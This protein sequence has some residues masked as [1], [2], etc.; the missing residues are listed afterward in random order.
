MTAAAATAP[1]R[2]V[3][4]V[5]DDALVGMGLSAYLEELGGEVTWVTTVAEALS[6]IDG[7]AVIDVAVVDLNLHG[8]MS[9]PVIDRLLSRAVPTILCT[10]YEA[11]SIDERFLALPRTEKP[12]TR[13]K[14][15]A[16]LGDHI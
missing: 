2:Q 12:F 14:I 15:R 6:L 11:S 3:L 10:G 13:A 4:V 5:E 9:N 8:V 1:A 16:L 7:A